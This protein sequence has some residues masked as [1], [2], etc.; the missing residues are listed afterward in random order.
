MYSFISSSYKLEMI[1]CYYNLKPD[2]VL[3][4]GYKFILTDFGLA[5]F[6]DPA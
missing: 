4:E 1:G 3:V 5:R 6:K 2:N